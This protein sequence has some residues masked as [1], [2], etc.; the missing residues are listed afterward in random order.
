MELNLPYAWGSVLC[1]IQCHALREFPF[2]LDVLGLSSFVAP[3]ATWALLWNGTKPLDFRWAFQDPETQ[4]AVECHPRCSAHL[5]FYVYFFGPKE[6]EKHVVKVDMWRVSCW[7]FNEYYGVKKQKL[8]Q[9][10]NRDPNM[11]LRILRKLSRPLFAKAMRQKIHP[12]KDV[13]T[14]WTFIHFPTNLTVSHLVAWSSKNDCQPVSLQLAFGTHFILRKADGRQEESQIS[15][16]CC[17][18]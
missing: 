18:V 17:T 8:S 2:T 11:E 14:V 15:C 5:S 13:R 10:A 1:M 9:I 6:L 4:F 3:S 12:N 16:G 7:T